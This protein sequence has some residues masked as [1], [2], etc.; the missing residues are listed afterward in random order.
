MKENL[1]N[2]LEYLK[3][4]DVDGC[5]TGSVMLGYFPDSNQD[6][7]IFAFNEKAF[8]KTIY[9]LKFNPMFTI[10][11]KLELWKYEDITNS[12]YNGSMKKLGIC[13]I[14]FYYNLSVPVNIVYKEKANNIFDVLSSFDMSIICKAYCLQTK[15]TLDLTDGTQETKICTWNKWNKTFYQPNVWAI[16]RVLRQ[17]LRVQKYT[18]RGYD[19]SLVANKYIELLEGVINYE[20]IFT[21]E[22]VD[23]KVESVKINGKILIEIIKKWNEVKILTKEEIILI[24]ELIKKM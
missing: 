4:L 12:S 2:C 14:K 10:L 21:S 18:D 9:T 24:D 17:F 19:C 5:I 22:K 3:T 13:S 1:D 16:S 20:N 15:Q 23:E 8:L 7:D 6:I 11:D